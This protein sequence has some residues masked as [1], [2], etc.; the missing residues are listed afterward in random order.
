MKFSTALQLVYF[1]VAFTGACT[2]VMF[3]LSFIRPL[4]DESTPVVVRVVCMLSPLLISIPYGIRVVKV[5]KRDQLR[6]GSA[7]LRAFKK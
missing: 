1:G 2:L 6:L 3:A 7:L 4:M 5:A